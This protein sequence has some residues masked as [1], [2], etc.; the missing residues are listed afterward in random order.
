[1]SDPKVEF[2]GMSIPPVFL[3]LRELVLGFSGFMV[4]KNMSF[5]AFLWFVNQNL[6]SQHGTK[7]Y[8]VGLPDIAVSDLEIVRHQDLV[9][10]KPKMVRT[11]S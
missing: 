7:L 8:E 3:V 6:C 4:N 2:L 10:C 9:R 11:A 5:K 1:M